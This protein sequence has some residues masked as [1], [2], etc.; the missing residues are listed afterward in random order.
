MGEGVASLYWGVEV[1][2]EIVN[3][4]IAVAETSSGCN[5]EVAY[6]LVDADH[7]F[8]SATLMSLCVKALAIPF[9][10][11]LFNAFSSSKSPVI[12]GIRLPNLVASIA[13]TRL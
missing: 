3:M 4:H 6:H 1:I 5:M 11:T 8:Y 7:A 2:D 10:L 9:S 12:R 13:T